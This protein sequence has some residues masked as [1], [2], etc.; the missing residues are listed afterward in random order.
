M[1]FLDTSF[2]K[3]KFEDEGVWFSFAVNPDGSVPRIKL[4]RAHARNRAYQAGISAIMARY[5]E[6]GHKIK[7]DIDDKV[8]AEAFSKYLVITWEN[9]LCPS[10]LL[11]EFGLKEGDYIP[12]SKENAHTLLS[13]RPRFLDDVNNKVMNPD[14]YGDSKSD[15]E[16][17]KN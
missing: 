4:C 16:S 15:E 11:T 13:N 6:Q 2:G 12:F 14:H 7:G 10:D 1:T 9:F 8:C 17:A 3:L 5:R